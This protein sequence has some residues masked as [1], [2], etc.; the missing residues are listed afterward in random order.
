[1]SKRSIAVLASAVALAILSGCGSSNDE[2]SLTK[3]E[4][5]KQG[6]AICTE[7]NNQSAKQYRILAKANNGKK[8]PEKSL[9]E[10]GIEVG[11]KVLVPN[12]EMR[13]EGLAELQPPEGDEEEIAAI[14]SAI[15]AG[16][17]KTKADPSSFYSKNYPFDEANKLMIKYGFQVC[18]GVN[19][20]G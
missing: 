2:E 13:A 20:G 12:A 11:E 15:E 10:E 6:D 5:I 19:R 9:E 1:M 16:V 18:G 7:S 8:A 4:F 3:A 14:V 17:E